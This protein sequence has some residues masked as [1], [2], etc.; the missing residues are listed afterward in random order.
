[1]FFW[2]Q[3]SWP[4]L[5][6]V[7]A[8]SISLSEGPPEKTKLGSNFDVSSQAEVFLGRLRPRPSLNSFRLMAAGHHGHLATISVM[9]PSGTS[10]CR[11]VTF[12]VRCLFILF[13][14]SRRKGKLK[15]EFLEFCVGDSTRPLPKFCWHEPATRSINKTG[16]QGPILRYGR[17]SE[18][19]A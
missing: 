13:F 6:A 18:P 17:K 7:R 9:P 1:M 10:E 8:R 4:R 19:H 14:A 15:H 12:S 16:W 2:P 11:K 3:G 5:V